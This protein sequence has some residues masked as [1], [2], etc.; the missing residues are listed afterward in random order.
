MNLIEHT[1]SADWSRHGDAGLTCEPQPVVTLQEGNR[2]WLGA[3][4]NDAFLMVVLSSLLLDIPLY[5]TMKESS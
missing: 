5:G 3:Y 2:K 1:L 4:S